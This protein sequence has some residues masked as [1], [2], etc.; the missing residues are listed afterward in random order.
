MGSGQSIIIEEFKENKQ[1]APVESWVT[2]D[3]NAE[4]WFSKKRFTKISRINYKGD[5]TRGYLYGY[6]KKE[7]PVDLEKEF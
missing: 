7:N 5:Y 1:E 4:Y 3:K 6:T 2:Q